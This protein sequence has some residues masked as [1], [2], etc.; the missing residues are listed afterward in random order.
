MFA[1]HDKTV[2]FII[3]QNIAAIYKTY[4][5]YLYTYVKLY[6]KNTLYICIR[7]IHCLL[8]SLLM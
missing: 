2:D 4:F 1:P 6:T 3:P 8:L 7:N 5:V